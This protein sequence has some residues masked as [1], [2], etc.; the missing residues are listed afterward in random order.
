VDWGDNHLRDLHH[1]FPRL[2]RR[3]H[4]RRPPGPRHPASAPISRR[5]T[6]I[7][8]EPGAT[9]PYYPLLPT[10]FWIEQRLWGETARG[11]HLLNICL[12]ATAAGLFGKIL[13]RLAIPGAWPAAALF[14]LHPVCAESVAQISEQKNGLSTVFYLMAALNAAI[15]HF[16]AA[17]TLKSDFADAL[18]QLAIA[19]RQ[20]GQPESAAHHYRQASHPQNAPC[21]LG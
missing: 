9:Q 19:L 17:L 20:L 8:F 5:L 21:L 12:H 6:R 18:L 7:W 16:R 11:Y 4:L 2:E 14:A 13:Q 15:A 3:F 1:L 10:A